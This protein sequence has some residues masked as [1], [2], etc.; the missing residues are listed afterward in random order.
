MSSDTADE[1]T[2]EKNRSDRRDLLQGGTSR[3]TMLKAAAAATIGGL[4]LGA[5]S[6]QE[7]GTPTTEATPA[8]SSDRPNILVLMGDDIGYWNISAY[9]LGMMG[10]QTPNIDRIAQEGMIFTDAYGE[11]SC[12]AGRAA[13]ITGQNPFRTGLLSIGMPADDQGIQAQDPT[14]ADLLKPLGYA[15]GQFGKNH[16]G[17]R[18]E[19][20]PTVHGFDEFFGV[21]YHLNAYEEPESPDYPTDPAFFEQYG[22]RNILHSWASEEDDPTEDPRFGVVGKQ[23]LADEGVLNTERMQT[24][25]DETLAHTLHFI[26]RAHENDEPFFVWFNSTRMHIHTHLKPASEGA[27]GLGVEADGMVETDGHV[28][29]LLQQLDDLGIADNT[30]VIYTTDNGAEVFSWPDGGT[31]PFRGEKNSNWEGAYRIPMMVRWPGQIEAGSVSNDIFSLQDWLPT[32]LTAVGVPNIKDELLNG[33]QAG[34]QEFRAHIDGYNQ[35]DHLT[36][37]APSARTDF[38]YFSDGGALVGL[39]MDRWK[40]VFMEQLSEGLDVWLEPFDQL[41]GPRL[42][43]LR[44]DPFERAM[45]ESANYDMWLVDHIYVLYPVRDILQE[46]F[47]TF[48]RFPPQQTPRVIGGY[49]ELIEIMRQFRS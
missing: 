38:F 11:Q 10:F 8:A 22:P 15:T 19:F 14:I 32:L 28:G 29:Q 48:I 40:A 31:T 43:D 36:N 2:K 25:D 13:F 23:V 27:T 5:A 41:R 12:T 3:R 42:V 49:V 4:G 47:Q 24:F 9:S 30:I 21:L 26:N 39:R 44:A 20:L 45:V 33:Y 18:N 35:L 6:A 34:D 37:G 17:D 46:F 1:A 16:L 7:T